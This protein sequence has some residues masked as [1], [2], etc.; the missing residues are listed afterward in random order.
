MP[1]PLTIQLFVGRERET[2]HLTAGGVQLQVELFEVTSLKPSL[3]G[4]GETSQVRAT[5]DE[6]FSLVFRGPHDPPLEQS[7]YPMTHD[8]IGDLGSI[9]IVPIAADEQGRYYQAVF[10]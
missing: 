4:R 2:F 10:N 1:E 8:D 6:P 9:F 7:M 5:K 3:S